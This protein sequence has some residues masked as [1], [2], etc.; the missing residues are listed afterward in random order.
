M[1]EEND[2]LSAYI[3]LNNEKDVLT[4]MERQKSPFGTRQLMITRS[5]IENT[6]NNQ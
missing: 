3:E 4:A 2:Q 1:E 5:N 6:T